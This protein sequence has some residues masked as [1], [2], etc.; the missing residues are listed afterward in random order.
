M[1]R[2]LFPI[3]LLLL[4]SMAWADPIKPLLAFLPDLHGNPEILVETDDHVRIRMADSCYYDIHMAQDT[5]V[6][7]QTACAPI[8]SSC[9]RVYNKEWELLRQ[10]WPTVSGIFPQAEYRDGRVYWTDNTAMY[11]DEEERQRNAQ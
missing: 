1:K 9:V 6:V 10:L 7:I 5:I 4:A 2:L 11:L 3:I 8:C